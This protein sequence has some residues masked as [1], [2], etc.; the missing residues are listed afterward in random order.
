VTTLAQFDEQVGKQF[1][2]A[3]ADTRPLSRVVRT[4]DSSSFDDRFSA[5]R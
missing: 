5:V 3:P 1:S 4:I 2:S